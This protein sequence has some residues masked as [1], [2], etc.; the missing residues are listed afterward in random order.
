MDP[1]T[2]TEVAQLVL[3]ELGRMLATGS[4]KDRQRAVGIV[5]TNTYALD[6]LGQ[7]ARGEKG[8]ETEE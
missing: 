5:I 4:R 2:D 8:K 1:T 3:D 7:I 6:R